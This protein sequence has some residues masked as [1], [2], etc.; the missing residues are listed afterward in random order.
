MFP[1]PTT[2][3]IS[4]PRSCTSLISRAIRSTSRRSRPYSCSPISASPDSFM[5]TRPKTGLAPSPSAR[6]GVPDE[7]EH[8]RVLLLERLPDRLA[9]VDPLLVGQ[10][11]LSEEALAEHPVDDLVA[12]LLRLRLDFLGALEDLAFGLELLRRHLAARLVA[13]GRERDVH[14]Q[15]ARQLRRAADLHEHADL[16]RRRV[17]V[18]ADGFVAL[19]LEAG[20]AAD[21]D[22]LTDPADE[23][24]ALVLELLGGVGPIALDGLEHLLG[25]REK[26]L[27]LR[28]RLGLA[29][30]RDQRASVLRDPREHDPFSGLPTRAFAGLGHPALA[31]EP[32]CGLDVTARLLEGALAVHHPGA[33]LVPEL[34]DEPGWNLGRAHWASPSSGVASAASVSAALSA[35]PIGSCST[36]VSSG[37]G[38]GSG[39]ASGFGSAGASSGW[40]LRSNSSAVAPV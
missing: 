32:L 37:A 33:R 24:D 34:L 38:S 14:G 28:D 12:N 11:V 26:L 27:V 36:G 16:V 3:A 7:F 5:S 8:L 18:R 31:Q 1:A 30:H 19:A 21:G 4:T 13:R 39:A 35:W 29:A 10:D 2:I 6:K 40:P 20:R 17:D 22:V 23:L 9:V 15:L 25:E